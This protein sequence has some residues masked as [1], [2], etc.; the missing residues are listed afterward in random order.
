MISEEK[1]KD[2]GIKAFL[3]KPIVQR[4]MAVAIYRVLDQV[5]EE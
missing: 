4:D 1:A 2:L 5:K 3:M